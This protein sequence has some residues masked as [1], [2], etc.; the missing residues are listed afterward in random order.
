[1]F[2]IWVGQLTRTLSQCRRVLEQMDS[3]PWRIML[4]N[5]SLYVMLLCCLLLA[6]MLWVVYYALLTGYYLL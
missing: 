6:I 4:K 5:H 2:H 3:R 1:M